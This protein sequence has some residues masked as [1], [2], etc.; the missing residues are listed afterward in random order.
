MKQNIEST[1]NLN[2]LRGLEYQ[3]ENLDSRAN[4][5]SSASDSHSVIAS[6]N[7]KTKQ[8]IK[9]SNNI[10]DSKRDSELARN[11]KIESKSISISTKSNQDEFKKL[12]GLYGISDTNLTPHKTIIEQLQKAI[13]GGLRIFQYRDKHSKDSDIAGLVREL[14][15]ICD[16]NNVLF[17]LNDR[18]EL[19]IKLGVSGL[20][21]GKD[22]VMKLTE[23]RKEFKGIIGIS[24]YDSIKLAKTFQDMGANYVAFGA[25]FAS[26]TKVNAPPCPLHILEQAKEHIKI[27]ICAIGGICVS[28][29]SR[30]N[31]CDM[32]AVISSLWTPSK[33]DMKDFDFI[34]DNARA[35][36]AAWKL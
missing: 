1:C 22:E 27:P 12:K 5:E 31:H 8:S 3:I 25:M 18:Y 17:V 21:L 19:A 28:N 35:L 13:E 24:C 23:I 4:L 33:T 10:I 7:N 30:L 15:A 9:H 16:S 34:K 2:E 32:I 20:H 36:L 14:Q 11:F 26:K 6:F 29:V